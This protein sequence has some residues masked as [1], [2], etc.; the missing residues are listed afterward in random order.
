MKPEFLQIA[1][2]IT[3][4]IITFVGIRNQKDLSKEEALGIL[5]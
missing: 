4:N 5:N 3:Q 2:R 1:K